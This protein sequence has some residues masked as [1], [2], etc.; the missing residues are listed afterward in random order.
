MNLRHLAVFH[1]VA[2]AGSVNAAAPLLRTSQPAVSREL[3]TLEG[4]LGMPLFDRLPRGMRLTEAGQVLLS[5]AERIFGIEQAAERAMRELADLESGQLAIGASNTI[6][7]YL[8]PGFIA[9]YH[10]R[11]PRIRLSLE[12]GNTGE[13]VKGIHDARFTLAFVEGSVHDE[14]LEVREI[15]RDRIVAV[16]SPGH[17]LAAAGR[18]SLQALAQTPALLREHGSGTREI[19]DQALARHGLALDSFLEIG[20]SEAL[21]RVTLEGGGVGWLSELCVVQ[22]LAAGSLVALD[23]AELELER[24]LF[25]LTLRG[26]HLAPSALLFLQQITNEWPLVS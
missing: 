10:R 16:A 25:A 14:T 2:K 22:E 3:Q 21:K 20:N 5:Y 8:L 1:A 7:T 23:T 9:R 19:V 26:R 11:Y 18:A 12:I 15:R 6:G 17:P 13:V 4:R 24:P